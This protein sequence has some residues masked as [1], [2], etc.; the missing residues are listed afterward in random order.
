L[1]EKF[2][3][4]FQIFETSLIEGRRQDDDPLHDLPF[5]IARLD[6][7]AR[8]PR[9]GALIVDSRYDLTIF[10]EAHKL[11]ARTWGNKVIKS[12]RFECA[13]AVREVCPSLLLMTAT[14]HNGKE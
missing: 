1:A 2:A 4:H 14:P 12:K 3:L 11:A 5:L 7:F 13:E 10:D 8:S 9:F 6:Q